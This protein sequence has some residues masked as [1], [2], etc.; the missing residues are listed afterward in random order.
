MSFEHLKA[1]V[2]AR[3][4]LSKAQTGQALSAFIGHLQTT[5]AQSGKVSLAGIGQFEI[6]ERAARRGRNPQTG[7]PI[8]IPASKAVK[9]KAAK[10]LKNAVND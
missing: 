4:S 1:A 6:A 8:G 10:A 7:E 5:L 9:F 2:A 3:A